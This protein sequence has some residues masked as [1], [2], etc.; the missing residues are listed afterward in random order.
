MDGKFLTE[1][2]LAKEQAYF[3]F[4]RIKASLVS[5]VKLDELLLVKEE[6]I[7]FETN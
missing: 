6:E 5:Y 2:D 1:E 7:P 4:K 3:K